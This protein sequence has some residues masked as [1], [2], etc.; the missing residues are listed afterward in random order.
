MLHLAMVRSPFAH[1]TIT[2]DRH[3]RRAQAAPDVVAVFTGA[4]L[5]DEQGALPCAWPITAGQKHPG[6]PPLAVDRGRLR[7][8]GRRRRGRPQ[9]RR[10]RATPPSSST[11]T[12]RAARRARPRGGGRRRRRPGAPRPR[13]QQVSATWMFDSAEAGTGGDVERGH[14]ATRDGR[15]RARV[16]PAAADPGV[17][18]AA[19]GRR[20]PD[21][22]A[23]H[24]CG[25]RPRSRTSCGSCWPLTTGI[26]EHK[27]R[28]IAPDVGGGFGGKLQVTPEEVHRAAASPGGSASR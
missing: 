3:Q 13:H 27:L 26:P 20:R 15:H 21:R 23:D 8:R 10:G 16:P 19:L 6:H 11:S 17:H 18:G 24:R 12:T 4:D 5:A 22:R 9:R 28:V 2:S 25:R 14:R 1:A 7:R